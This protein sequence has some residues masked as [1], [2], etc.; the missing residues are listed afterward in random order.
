MLVIEN[1]T[2]IMV[3]ALV[4][5]V[6]SIHLLFVPAAAAAAAAGH[7]FV[8]KLQPVTQKLVTGINKLVCEMLACK[9]DKIWL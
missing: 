9:Y 1:S 6:L 5:C 7:Q 4:C 8:S 2:Q 3:N